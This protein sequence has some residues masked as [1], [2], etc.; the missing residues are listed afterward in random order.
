MHLRGLLELRIKDGVIRRL[1]DKWLGA[2]VLENG[3]VHRSDTVSTVNEERFA[4]K[5]PLCADAIRLSLSL[6]SLATAS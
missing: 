5:H 2:G 4:M 3:S 1:I 6:A